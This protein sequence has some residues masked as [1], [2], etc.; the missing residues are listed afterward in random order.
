[1]STSTDIV[2]MK[3]V[4]T[5][6][7][8]ILLCYSGISLRC[9]EFSSALHSQKF[10]LRKSDTFFNNLIPYSDDLFHIIIG[11][12]SYFHDLSLARLIPI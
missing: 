8:A 12:F 3:D 7:F 5:V 4:E 2:W 1:M 6:Y 9:K 11:V 10:F